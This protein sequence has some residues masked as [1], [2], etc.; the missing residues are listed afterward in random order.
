MTKSKHES[1]VY[2]VNIRLRLTPTQREAIGDAA[3]A[4]GCSVAT[5]IRMHAFRAA[6]RELVAAAAPARPSSVEL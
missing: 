5:F 2:S 6:Q 3:R 4:A 1:D